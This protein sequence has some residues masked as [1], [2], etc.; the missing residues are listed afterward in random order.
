[1]TVREVIRRFDTFL[2][3]RYGV[4]EFCQTEDCLLRLSIG[5]ARHPLQLP[6][7][8]VPPGA[9]VLFLHLWN[10]R[11]PPIPPGGPD[12]NWAIRIQ[13]KF[14]RSLGYAASYLESNLETK[15]IQAVGGSTSLLSVPDRSGGIRLVERLGFTVLP[16]R[17]PLGR[18]GEFWDNFY[19][20]WLIWAYNPVSLRRRKLIRLRRVEL[21]MRACDFLNRYGG[22]AH[23]GQPTRS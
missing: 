19:A 20:W 8:A 23:K 11:I 5:K 6:G 15:S 18:F 1:M 13:R 4:F 9:P 21:W 10:T 16:Y 7:A 3:A 14:I 2:S 17:S 12:F 22:S